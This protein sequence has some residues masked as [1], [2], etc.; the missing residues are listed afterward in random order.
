MGNGYIKGSLSLSTGTYS[1]RE[2]KCPICGKM[3]RVPVENVFWYRD[4]NRKI[5]VC[6]YT[7]HGKALARGKKKRK[8]RMCGK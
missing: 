8:E 1:K 4:G 7:C 2:A 3:F 5:D 6:G